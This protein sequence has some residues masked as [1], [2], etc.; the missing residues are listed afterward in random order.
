[1]NIPRQLYFLKCTEMTPEMIRIF[2]RSRK[3]EDGIPHSALE[4]FATLRDIAW[5]VEANNYLAH[6]D[7]GILVVG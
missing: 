3:L 5:T 6:K 1:M 7:V 2:T 4:V